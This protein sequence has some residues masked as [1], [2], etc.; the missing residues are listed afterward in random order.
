MDQFRLL[1]A[2]EI[3]CRVGNVK[4][5]GAGGV[6]LLLYKDARCDMNILD[7]QVGP[8]NWQRKHELIDGQLFCSVGIY[9]ESRGCWIW[10][11]DVGVESRTEAEK[12]RAS[13][14]FKRACFNWG[15]GRELYT[16]PFIW[17]NAADAQLDGKIPRERFEVV[18]IQYSGR[19]ILAV[20]ILLKRSG[21]TKVFRNDVTPRQTA[22]D[23]QIT[24]A[25]AEAIKSLIIKGYLSIEG[26]YKRYG[27]RS[28]DGLTETQGRE[29]MA[30]V[31]AAIE[32]KKRERAELS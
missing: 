10:K 18:N 32:A 26:L 17:I 15:I 28:V 9:S 30:H 7:E 27:A 2:D 3:E 5:G 25:T 24:P 23:G 31:K 19:A 11:Q 14:A 8:E 1:R 29:I 22:A 20:E 21:K 12:G 4:E 13:D 16:A 6:S